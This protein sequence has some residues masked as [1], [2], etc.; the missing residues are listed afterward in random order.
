[1]EQGEQ[2]RRTMAET[3]REQSETGKLI[4]SEEIR[5][6]LV[7]AGLVTQDA[8]NEITDFKSLLGE[9]IQENSDLKEIFTENGAAY[10]YS[11][12]SLSETYAGILITKEEGP[13]QVIA[14]VVRDNS[15][16]YPRPVPLDIFTMS[17]FDLTQKEIQDCLAKIRDQE[18]YKDIARTT[19][20]V[21]TVFLY[22]SR[23]LEPDYAFT[24][25]EWLDVGQVN[26]P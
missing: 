11:T 23:H 8:T 14:L 10:Y 7:R 3:I 25:A 1:M 17:P 22:S 26:N 20:S 16:I 21:G 13:L 2:L 9:V 24:L 6:A 4:P 5:T 15:K 19:T 18:E 12:R